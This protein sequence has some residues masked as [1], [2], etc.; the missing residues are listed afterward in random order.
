MSTRGFS[1]E[2]AASA[3][4]VDEDGSVSVQSVRRYADDGPAWEAEAEIYAGP[5]RLYVTLD[6]TAAR[7]MSETLRSNET[8]AQAPGEV[9]VATMPNWREYDAALAV[10]EEALAI[11][12]DPV[13][14]RVGL[15]EGRREELA[16]ALADAVAHPSRP[17]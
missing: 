5:V 14:I 2:V 17:E 3:E 11:V 8:L 4:L 1:G 16:N 7:E 10:E 6:G 13:E 12:T 15:D 9:M